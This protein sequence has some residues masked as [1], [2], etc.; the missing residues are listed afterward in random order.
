M[1]LPRMRAAKE[2]AESGGERHASSSSSS[3][4]ASGPPWARQAGWFQHK[5]VS[6]GRGG[7]RAK[8]RWMRDPQVA[9][10]N[11]WVYLVA[12]PPLL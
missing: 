1:F 5:T 6:G 12:F 4:N 7:G 9:C 10:S 8:L 2:R 11:R 3:R